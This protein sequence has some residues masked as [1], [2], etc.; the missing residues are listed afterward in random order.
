[1]KR[2]EAEWAVLVREFADAG[3]QCILARH[4]VEQFSSSERLVGDYM[5]ASEHWT[6]LVLKTSDFVRDCRAGASPV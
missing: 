4:A 5:K 1:M 2:I 6:D 3:W